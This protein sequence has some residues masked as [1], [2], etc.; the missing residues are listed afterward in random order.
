MNFSQYKY[1][2]III[3]DK[4]MNAIALLE[5]Y[6]PGPRSLDIILEH[7]SM[8]AAKAI[9]VA[10]NLG[11]DMKFIEEAAL[12]HDIGVC[13][14]TAPLFHCHGTEPY[15]RHG[16][17]GR[18]ILEREGFPRHALLCERHIGVGL[19]AEDIRLQNL[20]LP[21]RDMTPLSI[22]EKIVCFAD[23]FYSK[24][25]GKI[26]NEKTIETIRL[27]LAKFGEHK[28]GIFNCWLDKFRYFN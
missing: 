24:Y 27:N 5:K 20:P 15:I 13:R 9:Q 21:A 17:I 26:R 16:I 6:F 8:V 23:L 2:F 14:T 12:I 3:R 28:V 18:E 1:T 7:S 19:T 25:P 22:E 11:V 4:Q 10:N